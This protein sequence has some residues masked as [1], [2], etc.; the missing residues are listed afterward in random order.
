MIRCALTLL[1]FW[2]GMGFFPSCLLPL[3]YDD[4]V[5]PCNL[6]RDYEYYDDI[7]TPPRHSMMQ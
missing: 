6:I 3:A 1:S 2:K 7:T 4:D 5:R